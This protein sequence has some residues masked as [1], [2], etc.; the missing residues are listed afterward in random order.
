MLSLRQKQVCGKM[1]CVGIW[2]IGKMAHSE[3]NL[4]SDLA[5]PG[6]TPGISQLLIH[7]SKLIQ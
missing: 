3:N 6:L 4:T 2:Y 7:C 1:M 5:A